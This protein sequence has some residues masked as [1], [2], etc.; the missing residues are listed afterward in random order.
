MSVTARERRHIKMIADLFERQEELN[1]QTRV[2]MHVLE[3]KGLLTEAEFTQAEAAVRQEDRELDARAGK[4]RGELL[5]EF[6]RAFEG[7]E[8]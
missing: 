3:G 7:T 5:E 1:F 2:L 8:Q 4:S 6:L